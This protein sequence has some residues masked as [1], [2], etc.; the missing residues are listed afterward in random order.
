MERRFFLRGIWATCAGALG[1]TL[2]R[3]SSQG[4]A[5]GALYKPDDA[6]TKGSVP[7]RFDRITEKL[8]AARDEL[9]AMEALVR[10]D[11]YTI[12]KLDKRELLDLLQQKQVETGTEL[13]E[14]A[15]H[16]LVAGRCGGTEGCSIRPKPKPDEPGYKPR[17]LT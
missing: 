14:S 9:T 2:T 4:H 8:E 15:V 5:K 17:K 7:E 10:K 3:S 11:G 13:S 16:L 6:P 12:A 1:F